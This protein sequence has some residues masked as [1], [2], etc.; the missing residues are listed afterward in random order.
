MFMQLNTFRKREW[1]SK[2]MWKAHKTHANL[3]SNN[4][5]LFNFNLPSFIRWRNRALSKLYKVYPPIDTWTQH[6]RECPKPSVFRHHSRGFVSQW[7]T[8]SRKHSLCQ[9]Q[10]HKTE[11][12]AEHTANNRAYPINTRTCINYTPAERR[13]AS[14]QFVQIKQ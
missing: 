1:G 12:Y 4:N 14:R 9:C 13:C 2:R 6:L 3:N 10:C 11:E 7:G 5:L 8:S